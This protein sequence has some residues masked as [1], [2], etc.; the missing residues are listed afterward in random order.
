MTGE[1]VTILV[2]DDNPL[3]LK[4]LFQYLTDEGYR[5]LVAEDGPS[6]VDQAR[7]ALPDLILLD[8]LM[9]GMN[10]FEACRELKA[11][12]T[13]KGIPVIFLTALSAT[14]D[15]LEGFN[16]GGVDYLTKPLQYDEVVARV[17]THLKLSGLQR[18]LAAKNKALEELD[19][20]KNIL[21]SILAHDLRSPVVT[22][23]SGT[24]I[25][26]ELTQDGTE[27]KGVVSELSD[28]ANR[29]NE[30][31]ENLLYWSRLVLQNDRVERALVPAD[32]T[33]REVVGLVHGDAQRKS[34]DIVVDIA[35]DAMLYAEPHAFTSI[36]RN[37]LSNAMKFTPKGGRITVGATMEE[38]RTRVTVSDTGTG[39]SDAEMECIFD[40]T[41]RV[42]KAGTEGEKGSGLGLILCKELVEGHGGE[43]EVRSAEGRGTEFSFWLPLPEDR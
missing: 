1:Q 28:H 36:M 15:K 5:V 38:T 43:I 34:Q 14:V 29:L 4:V 21:L 42:R 25:L 37:L 22:F 31:L 12:E 13:T 19:Q 16:S 24:R 10:G 8:V 9:P 17:Q 40:L 33:I 23:V 3:N 7:K 6:A 35:P 32:R 27:I 20:K 2:V 11:D 30:L 18:E 26:D 39:L 41:R